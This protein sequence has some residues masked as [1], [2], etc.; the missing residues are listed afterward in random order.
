M[1]LNYL[2]TRSERFY[3]TTT[4]LRNTNNSESSKKENIKLGV[5]FSWS[6]LHERMNNKF[7]EKCEN[8]LTTSVLPTYNV[9][10][11]Q[12]LSITK[13]NRPSVEQLK[14]IYQD[15]NVLLVC[16]L[17][18]GTEELLRDL[19]TLKKPIVLLGD[20]FN[21]SLASAL[22]LRQYFRGYM[23]PS[24]LVNKPELI[25]SK[26][27]EFASKYEKLWKSFFNMKLGLIGDISPWL[28]NEK[29]FVTKDMM[30]GKEIVTPS[31][32]FPFVRIT[33]KELYEMFKQV[34][35][36]DAKEI[37][38][39]VQQMQEQKLNSSKCCS[40]KSAPNVE[41]KV[42]EKTTC[43]G[44][45][46]CGSSEQHEEDHAHSC[47]GEIKTDSSLPT[48]PKDSLIE[49]SRVYVAIQ[50]ILSK[51]KLDGF[52]IGCFDLISDINTTPCLALGLLNGIQSLKLSDGTFLTMKASACEGE[53]NSLL[54]MIICQK[55]LNKSPFMANIVDW[56]PSENGLHDELLIAHCT[57][58]IIPGL[59]FEITTHFESGQGVAVRVDMPA[60]N[61]I[62]N[63]KANSMN[64][65][66]V[67]GLG[68]S[69]AMATLIKMRNSHDV[70]IAPVVVYDRETSPLRC[71]TQLRLRMQSVE[72]FVDST[73]GNHHLLVYENFW[74]VKEIFTDLGFN[75]IE[76]Y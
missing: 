46:K 20:S 57:S 29:D 64:S 1:T 17:T 69:Q 16:P 26:I 35:T 5:V 7:S 52:T 4:S 18:G 74:N 54:G 37:A 2:E 71:R 67:A 27:E 45:G 73:F 55:F 70:I 41:P 47:A 31:F 56:T 22:E 19:V 6:G 66:M 59:P 72:Q 49:A 43:C 34:S 25:H 12:V 39:L 36:E 28:I 75:V 10:R 53:L 76:H 63:I 8:I 58:P 13:Q 3:T 30:E 24:S 51:Y 33:T 61:R 42:E 11:E 44:G 23:I 21:N 62:A 50:R 65:K 48:V 9:N 40:S 15:C 68:A 38:S 32:R 60:V 14:E